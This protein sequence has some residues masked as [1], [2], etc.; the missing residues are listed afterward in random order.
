MAEYFFR[1][2]LVI[3]NPKILCGLCKCPLFNW[4]MRSFYIL[5][6]I[7]LLHTV[8]SCY[9]RWMCHK[10]SLWKCFCE[11]WKFPWERNGLVSTRHWSTKML[12]PSHG[13]ICQE[14]S[15]VN[16]LQSQWHSS[17]GLPYNHF[18]CYTYLVE[19]SST[20]A[21][22]AML[23]TWRFPNHISYEIIAPG[24]A[25]WERNSVFLTL[26]NVTRHFFGFQTPNN[27]VPYT[28]SV[29]GRYLMNQLLFYNFFKYHT[30]YPNISPSSIMYRLADLLLSLLTR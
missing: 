26:D 28:C 1:Y 29:T 15:A 10:K 7:P 22:P 5:H 9:L 13:L 20:F 2:S 14:W 24:S 27:A 17:P 4:V 25:S 11:Y 19:N 12:F 23:T 6:T 3:L 16:T 18:L 30:C 8:N 21:K